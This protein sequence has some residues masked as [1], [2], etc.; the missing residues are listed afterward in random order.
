L[1]FKVEGVV[2]MFQVNFGELICKLREQ[3]GMSQEQLAEGIMSRVNLSLIETGER[4]PNNQNVF[5]LLERLGY[6]SDQFMA[7]SPNLQECD[8]V[9]LREMFR[10]AESFDDI[11]TMKRLLEEMDNCGSFEEGLFLQFK[12]RCKA[13][14]CWRC[15]NDADTAHA[16]LLE[17]IKI[18]IPRFA[19]KLVDT[20][21]FA[22]C[23]VEII[24]LMSSIHFAGN[25]RKRATKLLERLA[26][27]IKEKYVTPYNR[28]RTLSFVYCRLGTYL[29]KRGKY[30]KALAVS[31]EGIRLAQKERILEV[32]PPLNYNKACVLYYTGK[33]EE[34]KK[35]IIQVYGCYLI[36][37]K[38]S[39]A[40]GVVDFAL[41][42]MKFDIPQ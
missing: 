1:G 13:T 23:D 2:I 30:K 18:T 10:D 24:K 29:G 38:E 6:T 22:T 32:L 37:G 7:Q 25:E 27:A 42:E 3:Q 14:I 8:A 16:I 17:A 34:S 26:K 39:R 19:E 4:K 36:L 28:A 33:E 31:E 9:I 41:N 12:L 5:A 35:L 15:D 21:L 20:Y 11:E 40:L